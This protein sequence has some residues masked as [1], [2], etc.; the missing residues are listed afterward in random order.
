MNRDFYEPFEKLL[1]GAMSKARLID[2]ERLDIVRL[3]DDS[4][5]AVEWIKSH[6]PTPGIGG[7]S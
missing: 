3:T 4:A 5:E 2:E 6:V 7:R 1:R